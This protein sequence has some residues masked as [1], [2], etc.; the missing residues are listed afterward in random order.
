MDLRSLEFRISQLQM[1]KFGLLIKVISDFIYLNF[2][3]VPNWK[4]RHLVSIILDSNPLG[5]VTPSYFPKIDVIIPL[6]KKDLE[7]IEL[8]LFS[9]RLNLVNKIEKITVVY[10]DDINIEK[11][12]HLDCET[13][14]ERDF[15]DKRLTRELSC[16]N[17]NSNRGWVM[18]QVIKLYGAMIS[19][20]LG[21]FVIDGDTLLT[22]SRLP[23]IVHGGNRTM[24]ELNVTHGYYEPYSN[25]C[26]E[27]FEFEVNSP[28]QFVAHFQ[29]MQSS[30][31]R[32]MFPNGVESLIEMLRK[33]KNKP[34][35]L[36]LSEFQ[37][38]GSF[39][40]NF[41]PYSYKLGKWHNLACDMIPNF[42]SKKIEDRFAEVKAQFKSYDS[43][44]FHAYLRN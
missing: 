38:Y 33:L 20:N 23:L 25:F 27:M 34:E 5:Q 19:K 16:I 26:K 29:M 9:L 10:A 43:V 4:I 21:T 35:K 8:T 17:F 12:I 3:I 22:K 1:S 36:A 28:F 30:V 18:Q 31:V 32:Q 14:H 11:I 6:S 15:L 7:T 37:M 40:E 2:N 24:Q 13:I 42:R 39:L 41:D 44:S